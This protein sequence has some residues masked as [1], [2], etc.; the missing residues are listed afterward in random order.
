MHLF[1]SAGEPSGDLHAA[2]LI[3]EL[4]SRS[5]EVRFS[6]FAGPRMQAAGCESLFDLSSMPIM[7]FRDAIRHYGKFRGFLRKAAEWFDRNPPDAVVLI[8]Y[9]GF[10]WHVAA[11]AKARNIPVFYYGVPQMWAWGGWRIGKLRRLVDHVLCKLP[12][13][14]E[15]FRAR[16]VAAEW[17]GHPFFDETA[18]QESRLDQDLIFRMRRADSPLLLLLPGSRDA[19]V[20]RHW[21]VLRQ[22]A[23]AVCNSVP[24]VRVAVGCFSDSQRR[25]V[26]STLT[27]R[28]PGIDVFAG[29]TPELMR[30]ATCAVAC[31]GSVSLELLAARLPTVI[32]Y[33]PGRVMHALARRFLQCRNITLVNLMDGAAVERGQ[34]PLYDPESPDAG[35]LPMPEYLDSRDRSADIARRV[36]GWLTNPN[37]LEAVRDWLDRI[38]VRHARPGASG[39]AAEYILQEIRPSSAADGQSR[40]A[41]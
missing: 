22:A 41:A 31:S 24:G 30:A 34:A 40:R 13:E 21:P 11:A 3:G 29:R 28:W 16:G 17:V 35:A 25:Q 37:Q 26:E 18:R 23:R 39:R 32:V 33:R 38:A 7:F 10:H 4:G 5:P 12:F 20:E 8:D 15:W 27:D 1:I 14:P 9:P 36:T 2:N 6:G 19:E